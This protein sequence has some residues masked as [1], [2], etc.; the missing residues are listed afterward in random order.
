MLHEPEAT[1]F[2]GRTPR[3]TPVLYEGRPYNQ[4]AEG[5]ERPCPSVICSD[6]YLRLVLAIFWNLSE[7]GS[8]HQIGLHKLVDEEIIYFLRLLLLF[9]SFQ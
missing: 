2:F 3:V 9:F 8:L 7:A 5:N 1:H 6:N 4:A